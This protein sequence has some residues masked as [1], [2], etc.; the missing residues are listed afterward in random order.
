MNLLAV[1]CNV[2]L[3]AFTALVV[4]SDGPASEPAY[5]VF[6]LIC[7]LVPILN[8]VVISRI[9]ARS[10]WLGI[11]PRRKTS[12]GGVG[13]MITPSLSAA[14]RTVTIVA[15]LVFLGFIVW[16]LIDQSPHPEEEGFLPFVLL[17]ILTPIISTGALMLAHAR[18]GS[19]DLPTM[20]P[21]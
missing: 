2:L 5:I 11:F 20:K 21:A 1:V 4:A 8:V 13:E 7:F 6:S 10:G 18:P 3:F 17:M 16:A 19:P 9:G 15:N 14:L 12:Q